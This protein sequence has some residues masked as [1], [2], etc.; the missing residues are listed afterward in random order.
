MEILNDEIKFIYDGQVGSIKVLTGNREVNLVPTLAKWLMSFT[1]ISKGL[2]AA[3][4]VGGLLFQ[5]MR[6]W[7]KARLE[8]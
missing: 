8:E 3:I 2:V 7:L 1:V 6:W 5:T 4:L